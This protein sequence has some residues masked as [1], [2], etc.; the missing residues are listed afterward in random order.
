MLQNC[1][2]FRG[3]TWI[4][5]DEFSEEEL[6]AAV[7]LSGAVGVRGVEQVNALE[8]GQVENFLQLRV[9]LLLVPPEQLVP[10]RPC[11]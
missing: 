2:E 7:E 6:A 8:D 1:F 10:P 5:P 11:A 3:F 9:H 4:L